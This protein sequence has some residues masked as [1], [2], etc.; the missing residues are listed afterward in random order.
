MKKKYLFALSGCFALFGAVAAAQV[1]LNPVPAK[2]I[3]QSQ[4]PT[5]LQ[6]FVSPQSAA[7]N[8][9][10]GRELY[11]PRSVALDTTVSPPALY[12]ADPRNNRVLGWKDATSFANGAFADTVIGQKDLLSTNSQGP[13]NNYNSGLSSPTSIAVDRSGNL[14]VLDTGNNRILRFPKPMETAPEDRTADLVIGQT[15]MKGYLGNQNLPTPSAA[16]IYTAQVSSSSIQVVSSSIAFDGDGNLWLT[17]AG[18]NRILRYTAADVSGSGDRSGLSADLVLG[19]ADFQS[20]VGASSNARSTKTNLIQPGTLAF[21]QS[22]N[23]FVADDLGRVVAYQPPFAS[24]QS[25]KRILGLVATVAGQPAPAIVSNTSFG[26]VATGADKYNYSQPIGVFTVEDNLFV[27]DSANHR[28]LRYAPMSTWA[29]ETATTPSPAAEAVYGQPDFSSNQPNAGITLEPSPSTFSLPAG[30]A[31]YNGELYLADSGNNRVLVLPYDTASK[32]LAPATRLLGQIDFGFSAP[33]LIEGREFAPGELRV[34]LSSGQTATVNL[35]PAI[36]IDT[37][38]ETPRLYIADTGNNRI[39]GYADARKVRFGDRH[40]YADLVIGQVDFYRALR[41]S[42]AN[43]SAVP[44][45]TGLYLPSAIAVDKEGNLWVADTLNG[46]VV[47]FPRPFDHR[48]DPQT[49]DLVI[50][51]PDLTTKSTGEVTRDRLGAPAGLAF[52]PEGNLVVSDLAHNRV[53]MYR[54]PSTN[55]PAADLILGQQDDSSS[56]YGNSD[57]QFT[58]PLGV[59]VDSFGRLYVADYGNVRIVVFDDLNQQL[60]GGPGVVLATNQVGVI[61]VHLALHPRTE[62]LYVSDANPSGSYPRSRVVR[63]PQYDQLFASGLNPTLSLNEY[64]PRGVAFDANANLYV[65]DSASRLSM[66]FPTLN[67]VNGA[68]GFPRLAPAMI[69]QLTVPGVSLTAEPATGSGPKLPFELADLEVLVDGVAAPLY[70]VADNTIRLVIPKGARQTGTAEFLIRR[71][72]TGEYV[73][74]SRLAM[75][76]YS[77]GV[78]FRNSNPGNHKEQARAVNQDGSDNGATKPVNTGQEFTVFLTGYGAVDGLPDDGEAPGSERPLGGETPRVFLQVTD[79]AALECT[80]GIASTLD[81]NE[82]GVW[83]VKCKLP[84]LPATGGPYPIGFFV[85][86]HSMGSHLLKIGDSPKIPWIAVKQ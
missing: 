54:Q 47:R 53:L 62:E 2:V 80:S 85:I 21:D 71:P 37:N 73:A 34:V 9:V 38:S 28:I 12:V 26:L 33:N 8:L 44:S 16:T 13:V 24:S 1:V 61:P 36:A 29:E 58:L 76:P 75:S 74:S 5:T 17:D 72:S 70:R 18:N 55:G 60:D 22:G 50:G 43:D 31:Y 10:E 27:S 56:G 69:G 66:H 49:A 67:V 35:G 51:Q 40:E 20:R 4:Q 25:A 77:P 63:F 65:V 6:E 7:R 84:T 86:Y 15:S 39:L 45:A 59:V 46:R 78:L 14:F 81:P 32:Q 68:N 11:A 83:R 42:P 57:S 82:P 64:Y 19:Q 30:A 41:N 48:D 52:T 3:G 79:T 23:L